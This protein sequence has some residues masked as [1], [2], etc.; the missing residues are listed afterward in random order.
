MNFTNNE[1]LYLKIRIINLLKI[2]NLEQH[3]YLCSNI[4][5]KNI[6]FCQMEV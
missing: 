3:L 6:V 2:N 4:F 1:K 5:E